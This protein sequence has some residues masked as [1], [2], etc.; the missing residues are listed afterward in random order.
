MAERIR[1]GSH[2]TLYLTPGDTLA[3]DDDAPPAGQVQCRAEGQQSPYYIWIIRIGAGDSMELATKNEV[4]EG[5]AVAMHRSDPIFA[6][7]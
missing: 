5:T 6:D 7:R 1:S 4:Y 3:I 2:A